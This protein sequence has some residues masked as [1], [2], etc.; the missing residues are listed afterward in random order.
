MDRSLIEYYERELEYLY[1]SARSVGERYPKRASR[2]GLDRAT[3][4][5]SD[6]FVKQIVEGVAFLTSRLHLRLDASKV[7][8]GRRILE[9]VYPGLLS[10]IPS[11]MIAEFNPLNT[12][13]CPSVAT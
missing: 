10:Q 6:P 2:L 9:M 11:F 4:L 7:E 3:P 1:G 8:F 13:F 5:D 12:A